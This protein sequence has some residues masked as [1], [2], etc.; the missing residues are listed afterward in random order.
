MDENIKSL[1]L[2]E[3]KIWQSNL[4]T[5]ESQ[6]AAYGLTPPVELVNGIDA[7]KRNIARIQNDLDVL[8][9]ET[10]DLTATNQNV[11]YGATIVS[12]LEMVLVLS[13][14]NELQG[15]AFHEMTT[16]L[17]KIDAN[18]QSVFSVRAS[19]VLAWV[20]LGVA[21]LAVYTMYIM[22]ETRPVLFDNV[23]IVLF[24]LFLAAVIALLL[25]QMSI[26]M[27]KETVRN[28]D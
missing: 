4:A 18:T 14:R 26:L 7:A 25:R 6:A 13:Q 15:K 12:I 2:R 9:H 28:V 16:K 22:P 24:V 17:N 8:Q 11:H 20:I 23:F 27:H 19:K 21:F 3:L 1:K 10:P 5:L